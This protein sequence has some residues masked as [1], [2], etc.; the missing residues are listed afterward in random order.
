L[1]GFDL[2]PATYTFRQ[3]KLVVLTFHSK[4]FKKLCTAFSTVIVT[5]RGGVKVDFSPDR[6]MVLVVEN[7]A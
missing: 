7:P 1:A 2:G 5:Q 3:T 4:L 6:L